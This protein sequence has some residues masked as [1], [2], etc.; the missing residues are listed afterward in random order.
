METWG[1]VEA[2]G[3][4]G[5]PVASVRAVSD[6]SHEILPDMGAIYGI[7]GEVDINKASA[8]FLSDPS[9]IAPYF[10]FRFKNT[11]RAAYSLS[12]FLSSLIP[13]L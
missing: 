12:K 6:E 5:I 1:V 11:P 13:N 3:Q 4:S 7:N 2:A 10:K 9:L 8:Y